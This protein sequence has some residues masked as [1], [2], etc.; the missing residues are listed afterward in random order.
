MNSFQRVLVDSLGVQ[1][2]VN[3]RRSHELAFM[4]AVE[5]DKVR[6]LMTNKG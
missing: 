4:K 1:P 2:Q 5:L 6:G 3:E